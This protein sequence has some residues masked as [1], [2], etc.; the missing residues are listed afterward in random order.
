IYDPAYSRLKGAGLLPDRMGWDV[1]R[2]TS[3]IDVVILGM[4][5][6]VD[7]PELVRCQKLGVRIMSFPEFIGKAFVDKRNIVIAGSH[8]KTTIT[9]MLMH[10]FQQMGVKADYLLGGLLAGFDRMVSL[11]EAPI[12]VIEGD[13][14]LSSRIDPTSKM[15]HY[16]GDIVVI[17]G[18]EWDH[19]NVF[20]TMDDYVRPF[21]ELI[22]QTSDRD[23]QVVWYGEDQILAELI[24][25]KPDARIQGYT[26]FS[27][28]ADGAL[29]HEDRVYNMNV[30]GE[31]NRANMSAVVGVCRI[32]GHND[33]EVLEALTT[34]SG[35]GRRLQQ[36]SDHPSVYLDY[37][38]APS[39]L[40]A[41]LAAVQER[42]VQQRIL[43][44]Y[45]LHT[46]S[47][48]SKEF[49]PHYRNTMVGAHEAIV[50]YDPHAAEMKQMASLSSDEIRDGFGRHD[51]HIIHDSAEL[52]DRLSDA[53]DRYDVILLMSSGTF[54]GLD[55]DKWLA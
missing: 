21:S 48:L 43:A 40:R 8:G 18:I 41:T 27:A 23:G 51:L 45:E 22:D 13:E 28:T 26:P 14:Y 38:H 35:V 10:V 37:A 15:L 16:H 6:R 4:H 36:I 31:H 3:Q 55:H 34:F 19:M 50:F 33:H 42:H 12:A 7:N 32:L 17:T 30:F 49:L 46:Y 2:I 5:A 54:G 52:S 47:S 1:E 39:K 9:G 11:G 24:R 29:V 20:P 25:E 53:K 44:V